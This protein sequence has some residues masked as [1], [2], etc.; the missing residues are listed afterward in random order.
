MKKYTIGFL[1]A[2]IVQFLGTNLLVA[3]TDTVRIQKENRRIVIIKKT[4]D[5]LPDDRDTIEVSMRDMD[6]G[7]QY[8]PQPMAIESLGSLNFGFAAINRGNELQNLSGLPE[9]NNGKSFHIGLEQ[10]W[11][12]NLIAHKL[13]LWTGVRYDISNYRFS[14]PDTR[15]VDNK[16]TFTYNS[17]SL[18]KASKSKVVVNYIGVPISIGY[19]SNKL[20]V[21]EGFSIRAGV[22]AGYRVRTHS[23]VKTDNGNK[24]KVF[25]D[26]NF[27]D[28]AIS[29]FVYVAYNSIGI[30]AR[31]TTTPLFKDKQGAESYAF[32]FG[33]IMQ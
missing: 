22:N 30:Y 14:N 7:P 8:V 13:R 32:Q 17:D 20:A 2:L 10:A 15:L 12:F 3:Q 26:F 11:G 25:D 9:I 16:N 1:T 19:Q 4:H 6:E 18:S 31:M 28:F 33:I 29:P 23:K 27:N 5:S 21:D 24:D